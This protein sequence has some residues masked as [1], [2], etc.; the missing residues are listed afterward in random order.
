MAAAPWVL[1][2]IV[3]EATIGAGLGIVGGYIW[4]YG[5]TKP[6]RDKVKNYYDNLEQV[7]WHR[8]RGK[9]KKTPAVY[10]AYTDARTWARAN[11]EVGVPLGAEETCTRDLKIAGL[12]TIAGS[13]YL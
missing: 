9:T 1:R 8:A 6:E 13:R 2:S 11:A 3:R 4:Y 10:V 12:L 7:R 5:I